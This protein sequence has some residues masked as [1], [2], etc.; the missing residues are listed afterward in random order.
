[1]T[2]YR[3]NA[4]L[5][6]TAFVLGFLAFPY[7]YSEAH[8]SSEQHLSA[9]MCDRLSGMASDKMDGIQLSVAQECDTLEASHDWEQQYGGLNEHEIIAGIVYE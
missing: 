3:K 1:M 4:W 7:S 9:E 2:R 5:A 6:V 8:Q